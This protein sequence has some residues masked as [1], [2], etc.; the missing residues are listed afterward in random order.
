MIEENC[1]IENLLNFREDEKK[2]QVCSC[3]LF[4]S[5]QKIV[6]GFLTRVKNLDRNLKTSAEIGKSESSLSDSKVGELKLEVVEE[7]EGEDE[8]CF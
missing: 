4:R 3:E 8:E 2:S 1:E 7:E 6:R 5:R